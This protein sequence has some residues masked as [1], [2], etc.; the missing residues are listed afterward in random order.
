MEVDV[1]MKMR[2]SLLRDQ[3]YVNGQ[4]INAASG[5][6][7]DV[8]NPATGDLIASIPDMDREDV[9]KAI[10]I[11]HDAWPAYR[12]LTA[13]ERAALL[14]KWYN[15]IL[16]NKEALAALMTMECGKVLAE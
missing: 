13:K 12:D 10:D 5:K 6:T 7:F 4:W 3:A 8:I 2:N 9:R 14:R 16:E 15:L 1:E 11:A